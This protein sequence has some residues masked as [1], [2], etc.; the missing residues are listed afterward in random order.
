MLTYWSSRQASTDH[1]KTH[2]KQPTTPDQH[3]T[4]DAFSHN[5]PSINGNM[6]SDFM[7]DCASGARHIF[8]TKDRKAPSIIAA[9]RV[10][11]LK[12][13]LWSVRTSTLKTIRLD[14][15]G[16]YTSDAFLQFVS[17]HGFTL[18]FTPPVTRMLVASLN[19]L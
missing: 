1:N 2:R 4:M 8:F 15:E 12:H 11:F 17:E 10:L 7:T 5:V 13:P 18:E 6:F 16:A 14:S 19:A 3:F 9:L